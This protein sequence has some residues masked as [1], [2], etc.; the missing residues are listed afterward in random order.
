MARRSKFQAPRVVLDFATVQKALRDVQESLDSI[1]QGRAELRVHLQDFN[2]IA[3]GFQRASA[4]AAGMQARLPKVSGEN[5]GDPVILHLEDMRGPLEV[6]AAPG[7]TV[8]GLEKVTF[9]VAG[10][11]VLW[12]NGISAWSGVMQAPSESVAGMG[13]TGPQ[14]LQG[15]PGEQGEP[16]S[17]GVP[18]PAGVPG[19][20]GV[21][22]AAGAQGPAG[23]GFPGFDGVDGQDSFIPGPPGQQGPAGAAGGA[24]AQGAPGIGFPGFDG[25]DGA[26]SFIPGPPGAQ[27]PAG[28]VGS[29]GPIG[30]QGSQGP[31]G[32]PG[33]DDSGSV[34]DPPIMSAPYS[35]AKTLQ[36]GCIAQAGQ[37]IAFTTDIVGASDIRKGTG[38]G[39]LALIGADGLTLSTQAGSSV[40]VQS[41]ATGDLIGQ[42]PA[43]VRL[44]AGTDGVYIERGLSG[45]SSGHVFIREGSA[46][47]TNA[48]AYGQLWAD[49]TAPCKLMYR[50]DENHDLPL[51]VHC[52]NQL[53]TTRTVTSAAATDIV[54]YTRAANTD[55]VGTTYRLKAVVS[56][57]KTAV[58]TTSPTFTLAVGGTA[59]VSLATIAAD[60]TAV[61]GTFLFEVEG[62]V[63]VRVLGA[64]G[65][66][67]WAATLRVKADQTQNVAASA[68][69]IGR[70]HR[71]TAA[72]APTTISTTISQT[73]SLQGNLAAAVASNSLVTEVATIERLN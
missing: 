66:A 45:S 18:G 48:A 14:G 47:L 52:V 2:L 30:T 25:N 26:D 17:E 31:P 35:L 42:A 12:S 65:V 44:R 68:A 50:H 54:N 56:Y 22:G 1:S 59:L 46:A 51:N 39:A 64:A 41:S 32:A 10:V 11:V 58:T 27:G 53:T 28:S 61:A 71:M 57:I 8:N 3:G 37:Y 21:A 20:A 69:G 38:A 63:T 5:L 36:A 40:D 29:V 7:Q 49:N 33:Y 9:T 23:I 60:W 15:A 16:G 24:G 13:P 70:W 19:A 6:W 62:H 4:P 73:I 55:R 34:S 43:A 67:T 72:A